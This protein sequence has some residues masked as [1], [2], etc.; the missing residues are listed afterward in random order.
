MA[1]N[2]NK[3]EKL[4]AELNYNSNAFAIYNRFKTQTCLEEFSEAQKE[5]FLLIP[6]LLHTS[7]PDKIA[8]LESGRRAPAGIHLMKWNQDVQNTLQKYFGKKEKFDRKTVD[9]QVPIEFLS[10]M[11]SVGSIAYTDKSDFDYW[12][13]VRE[14]LSEDDK[15]ALQEKFI[16]IERWCEEEL[17]V[18]VHFFMTTQKQLAENNF[19]EVSKESCGSALG[20]LLKEEYY[21]GSLHIVGKVPYWW[22]IPCGTSDHAYEKVVDYLEKHPQNYTHDYIDIGNIVEIPQEEYL[23]GGLWQLNKGID[24]IFKSILKMAL[25]IVYSDPKSDK[26]LLSTMLKRQV[27]ENPNGMEYLDPYQNMI[28]LVLGYYAKHDSSKVE[29]LRRCFFMKINVKISRWIDSIREPQKKSELVMLKYC[30]DWAWDQKELG[31]WEYFKDLPLKEAKAFKAEAEGYMLSSLKVLDTRVGDAGVEKMM[32]AKDL[33][34]MENRLTAIYDSARPR[35]EWYYSVYKFAIQ[36]KAYTLR[37]DEALSK[38]ILYKGVHDLSQEFTKLEEKSFIRDSRQ[39]SRILLWMIYNG[40]VEYKTKFVTQLRFHDQFSYN[41]KSLNEVYR[42]FFGLPRIPSLDQDGFSDNPI[43]EK[44]LI[45]VNF[46][47]RLLEDDHLSIDQN[48]GLAKEHLKGEEIF[49]RSKRYDQ[50]ILKPNKNNI[51]KSKIDQVLDS[52]ASSDEEHTEISKIEPETVMIEYSIPVDHAGIKNKILPPHEDPLNAWT[53]KEVLLRDAHM[54]EM[55]NWGEVSIVEY[56]GSCWVVQ[57]CLDILNKVVAVRCPTKEMFEFHVGQDFYDPLR[58]KNRIRTL[59]FQILDFFIFDAPDKNVTKIFCFE[60]GGRSFILRKSK[61]KYVSREYSNF[62]R[63]FISINLEE[64]GR[65][66]YAFDVGNHLGSFYQK[67][68]DESHFGKSQ[69]FF[70]KGKKDVN[71][72]IVDED[73]HLSIRK[74]PRDEL[75]VFFPR[76]I[77]SLGIC[78]RR[79]NALK[80]GFAKEVSKIPL[81]ISWLKKDE[82]GEAM[83]DIT[84]DSLRL[85][86]PAI[87]R[88]AEV[89][90]TLPWGSYKTFLEKFVEEGRYVFDNDIAKNEYKSAVLQFIEMRKKGVDKQVKDYEIFLSDIQMILDEEKNVPLNSSMWLNLKVCVE[91]ACA[92]ALQKR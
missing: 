49:K 82:K 4:I 66:T 39:L 27:Y 44:V 16:K 9:T 41:I 81:T 86:T 52:F 42:S 15:K 78:I 7:N 26:T 64:P 51:Q 80:K 13:C 73:G 3:V 55:N 37:Y 23:G 61:D 59:I 10:L 20:K 33:V 21:R 12:C 8:L 91:Q 53:A 75:R 28:D 29:L 1:V 5:A 90:I 38:W 88:L 36:A 79:I 67:S 25:L 31:K 62:H 11:G 24:S 14:G 68:I 63:A 32:G 77:Y 72:I 18:E 6:Y 57:L 56:M 83:I 76:Y 22:V 87:Q 74:I 92:I 70:R 43:V 30:K 46:V 60:V 48:E 54:V 71:F 58:F 65:V 85:V 40:L 47:P 69:V 17:G 84:K 19:G 2:S 89:D 34:K 35:A 50:A 45:S